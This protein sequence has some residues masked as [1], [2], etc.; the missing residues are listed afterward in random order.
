MP[1]SWRLGRALAGP[2]LEGIPDDHP[3]VPL[4]RRSEFEGLLTADIPILDHPAVP[5]DRLYLIDLHAAVRL[6]EWHSDED[7]GVRCELRVFDA[8]SAEQLLR[9][10][11]GVRGD[12]KSDVETINAIQ[13]GVLLEVDLRWR[14][15]GVDASAVWTFAVPAEFEGP[16]PTA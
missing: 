4:G 3:V 8:E 16:A 7:S 13:E 5:H 2:H 14:I 12:D 9:D 6:D 10:E 15:V 1:L 11:P